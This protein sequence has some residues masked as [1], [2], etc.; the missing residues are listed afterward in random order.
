MYYYGYFRNLDT[1]R[2][3]KGWL[4]KVVVITNFR[5]DE[6]DYGGEL[7]LDGNSPFI[8]SYEGDGENIYKPYKCSTATVTLHQQ[9]YNFSFNDTKGGNVLVMLLKAKNTVNTE[10][11]V[12]DKQID[13]NYNRQLQIDRICY[14]I[15]WVGFATPNVYSQD[16]CNFY[17]SFQLEAQD[18]L[19]TLQYLPYKLQS[20]PNIQFL[21]ILK[22][23][24][25]QLRQYKNIYIASTLQ[26]PTLQYGDILNFM[27][28]DQRN[29]FDEDNK[30]M[31]QLEVIE[32]MMKYLNLS[33]IPYKDSIFIV[34]YEGLKNNYNEYY[35]YERDFTY[36]Y[37]FIH[38]VNT[39]FILTENKVTLVDFININK[40]DFSS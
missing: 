12:L 7:L 24:I 2:D 5:D 25:S 35:H 34:D 40:E 36:I 13:P 32:E 30:A 20:S 11:K 31:N 39:S 29:F 26:L 23:S 28:C 17:D 19:S 15:E 27:K 37:P 1:S 9:E 18:V 16:Y 38:E 21:Q 22:N 14:N 6:F 33:I 3:K 10:E 4:Y 8:V